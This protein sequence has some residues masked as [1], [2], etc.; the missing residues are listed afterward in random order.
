MK[1]KSAILKVTALMLTLVTLFVATTSVFAA[2]EEP[3]PLT[4]TDEI[5]EIA[6]SKIGFYESNI[7]EFTTWYYGYETDAY[8]CSIFVSWCAD[9]VGALETAVPKRAVCGSM[10][11]WFER[12][13]QYYPVDSDYIP[14]KGD[15]IFINTA[16]DGTDDIH[17]VEIVTR[18][19]FSGS[20]R[21]PK[22]RCIGG[23]TSDLNYNGSEYVTEKT[24]PV[25]GSRAQVVGYA[26][27]DYES[28]QGLIGAL[29]TIADDTVPPFFTFIYSKML[30]MLSK[31][32]ILLDTLT[33]EPAPEVPSDPAE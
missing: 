29:V 5:V 15:I 13:G 17:H 28:S 26:H 11:E 33:V 24:R 7:N 1:F 9:Q 23:N 32:E 31:I 25:N 8:W 14:Q 30:S 27:P 21:N 10:R 22:V 6:R 16:V 2:N 12:K 3:E 20:A 18:S 19:G 4:I